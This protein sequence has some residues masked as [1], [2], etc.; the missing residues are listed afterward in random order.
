MIRIDQRAFRR[1]LKEI[2]RMMGQELIQ[3]T[4]R[5]NHDSCSRFK[6]TSCPTRLLPGGCN[7]ARVANKDRRT[8]SANVNSQFEGVCG[9]YSF[10]RSFAQS[11][12]DLAA[13]HGKVARAIPAD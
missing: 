1:A 3:W 4:C 7:G 5:G 12:F 11:F 2:F 8:Q 6:T 9:D 10:D 13:L